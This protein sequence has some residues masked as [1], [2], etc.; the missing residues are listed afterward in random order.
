MMVFQDGGIGIFCRFAVVDGVLMFLRAT[1]IAITSV[2][3]PA[4]RVALTT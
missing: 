1:C 2:R 3:H 4:R